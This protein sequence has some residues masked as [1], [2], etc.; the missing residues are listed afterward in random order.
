MSHRKN[1]VQSLSG[2]QPTAGGASTPRVEVL[3]TDVRDD[4]A[5]LQKELEAQRR[6]QERTIWTPP[7]YRGP[8]S[9]RIEKRGS[10]SFTAE[11]VG[12]LPPGLPALRSWG[13]SPERAFAK[14]K[15]NYGHALVDN[16]VVETLSAAADI[17]AEAVFE[18]V[19]P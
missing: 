19:E 15:G 3:S 1:D 7:N 10:D 12:E 9:V 2:A 8:F 13:R 14:L 11:V 16:D 5:A 4:I 18:V 6:E 17:A